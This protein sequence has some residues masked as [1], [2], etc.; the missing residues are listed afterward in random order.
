[1]F[2]PARAESGDVLA[3]LLV[4]LSRGAPFGEE[5][6]QLAAAEGLG[7]ES[8]LR[9]QHRPRAQRPLCAA[10]PVLAEPRKVT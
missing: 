8:S 9:P 4:A 6:W 5:A 10:F 7:L 3:A 1:M 2:S